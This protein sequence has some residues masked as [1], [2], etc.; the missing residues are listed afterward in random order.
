MLEHF[1]I[2]HTVKRRGVEVPLYARL[3]KLVV[4]NNISQH[5]QRPVLPTNLS[6]P[7]CSDP[8]SCHSCS[9]T[10]V[11]AAVFASEKEEKSHDS[12]EY[13]HQA[14]ADEKMTPSIESNARALQA[15]STRSRAWRH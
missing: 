12:R 2:T 13:Y 5:T 6:K 9:W 8:C 15:I 4:S 1:V 3:F 14:A 10:G 11:K 7:P